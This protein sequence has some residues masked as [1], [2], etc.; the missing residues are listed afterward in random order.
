MLA[1]RTAM[2]VSTIFFI[3]WSCFTIDSLD[4]QGTCQDVCLFYCF[5]DS[6]LHLP[7]SWTI[8]EDTNNIRAINLHTIPLVSPPQLSKDASPGRTNVLAMDSMPTPVI[9]K[10]FIGASIREINSLPHSDSNASVA[11]ST[12]LPARHAFTPG[13]QIERSAAS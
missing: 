10:S 6:P 4:A 7:S 12:T 8:V 2:S 1:P 9:A 13:M 3:V 11:P 5:V